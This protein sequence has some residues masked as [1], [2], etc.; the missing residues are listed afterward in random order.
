MPTL[1]DSLVVKLSFDTAD[2]KRGQS[3]MNDVIN[4]LVGQTR[5]AGGAVKKVTDETGAAMERMKGFARAGG[6]IVAGVA[7]AT[8]AVASK[9]ADVGRKFIELDN[10]ARYMPG[11]DRRQLNA[12]IQTLQSG[13]ATHEEA[14]SSA[15]AGQRFFSERS[16]AKLGI[17]PPSQDF[18][19][20]VQ[21]VLAPSGVDWSKASN[22][23]I[24]RAVFQKTQQMRRGG[25]DANDITETMRL[26]GMEAKVDPILRWLE[27]AKNA[28][29]GYSDYQKEVAAQKAHTPDDK[30]IANFEGAA[31]AVNEFIIAMEN[32]KEQLLAPAAPAVTE[33]VKTLTDLTNENQK[34][35]GA[36]ALVSQAL[37]S[38][39]G[40]IGTYMAVRALVRGNRTATPPAPE[41]AA[42]KGATAAETAVK[43]AETEGKGFFARLGE[44]FKGAGKTIGTVGRGA[45]AGGAEG[46]TAG[47][48][49]F[50]GGMI[51]GGVVSYVGDKLLEGMFGIKIP[52]LF[53]NQ[54]SRRDGDATQPTPPETTSGPT[55]P[56]IPHMAEGGIVRSP[57][58]ALIGEAGP[59]AVVP[60]HR[61]HDLAPDLSGHATT[62][63]PRMRTDEEEKKIVE[64]GAFQALTRFS[65]VPRGAGGTEGTETTRT[66]TTAPATTASAPPTAPSTTTTTTR[67]ETAPT[68]TSSPTRPATPPHTPVV[69][70][71]P[72]AA[73]S[74]PATE[75]GGLG[76]PGSGLSP[77]HGPS[78]TGASPTPVS[79][80]AGPEP[81]QPTM[82]PS[83]APPSR[84]RMRTDGGG[85]TGPVG[86]HPVAA[87]GSGSTPPQPPTPA[88][89]ARM[90]PAQ[91]GADA[92]APEPGTPRQPTAHTRPASPGGGRRTVAAATGAGTGGGT[93]STPTGELGSLSAKYESGSRGVA[94]ISSGRGDPGGV[95]YGRHQL[96][97]NTGSM[98]AFIRSPEGAAFAGN[99]QGLQ[100]GTAAFSA[101]YKKTVDS[102]GSAFEKA[103]HDYI[104]RTHY[105]PVEAH[106]RAGGINTQDPAIQQALWSMGVQHGGAK[107]I[108]DEA[109]KSGV[110]LKDNEAVLRQ[111]YKSRT[112]YIDRNSQLSA[113]VKQSLHRRYESELRDALAIQK[114]GGATPPGPRATPEPRP[115]GPRAGDPTAPLAPGAAPP[116]PTFRAAARPTGYTGDD[117]EANKTGY[118]GDD[119]GRSMMRM[120]GW[121]PDKDLSTKALEAGRHSDTEMYRHMSINQ[122]RVPIPTPSQSRGGHSSSH[123]V[124]VGAV[125]VH[126]PAT[127]TRA[128]VGDIHRELTNNLIFGANN[129]MAGLGTGV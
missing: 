14:R 52:S 63:E 33:F 124:H 58:H 104:Q 118:T 15:L 9:I 25:S 24:N 110:N 45:A 69:V 59:E 46:A 54:F 31:K 112:E 96:A 107:R 122:L 35:A 7:G 50:I 13:G 84:T 43:A 125:H 44:F 56:S 129:S 121:K 61:V 16:R 79:A 126:T 71:T 95:S 29:K 119:E 86:P 85:T 57:T 82:P 93:P 70:P 1:I 105:A 117:Q 120:V 22:D 48:V 80:P 8:A 62:G 49:G 68:G 109:V 98:A 19:R 77:P 106:A 47:P 103:Q 128:I 27:D 12:E 55:P 113:A 5:T 10:Q 41:E 26:G 81:R 38:L 23:D 108:V 90:R 123:E 101:A 36:A 75:S 100:P 102:S 115:G 37:I 17:A 114:K 39:A 21:S 28:G 4:G 6:L 66:T 72:S 11:M 40:A 42:T 76:P 87:P 88:A 99:F 97:S 60:L 91:S 20:F 83:V 34:T 78:T 89:R 51:V 116:E 18:Q 111:L 127:D 94:T 2:L 32:A 53:H 73:P 64:D 65:Q 67:T 92:P 74:T 30:Q 3:E